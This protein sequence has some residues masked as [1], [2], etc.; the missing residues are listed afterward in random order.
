MHWWCGRPREPA[1]ARSQLRVDHGQLGVG[2]KIVPQTKLL[3]GG[4][5]LDPWTV[6]WGS[7]GGAVEMQCRKEKGETDF[8]LCG[9]R[10]ASTTPSWTL[11]SGLRKGHNLRT[12][13]YSHMPCRYGWTV[14][15][16][17]W[18]HWGALP[19][20]TYHRSIKHFPYAH[21]RFGPQHIAEAMTSWLSRNSTLR[22]AWPN[23]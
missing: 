16:H 20:Q 6:T 17:Q 14:G 15:L 7:S 19:Q 23:L 12:G 10:V 11:S 9:S 2:R 22:L 4:Y 13:A 8:L 18:G 1:C 3:F 5:D 21:L